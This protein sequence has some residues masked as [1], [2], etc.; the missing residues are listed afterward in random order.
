MPVMRINM[1]EI[2]PALFKRMYAGVKQKKNYG[3]ITVCGVYHAFD[4]HMSTGIPANNC[5][6]GSDFHYGEGYDFLLLRLG[7]GAPN[8]MLREDSNPRPHGC[9]VYWLH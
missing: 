1:I 9:E 8:G 6:H 2:E 3:A 4:Q 7:R 5:Q